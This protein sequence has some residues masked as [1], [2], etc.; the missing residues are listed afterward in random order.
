MAGPSERQPRQGW[1]SVGTARSALALLMAALTGCY[2][3][4]SVTRIPHDKVEQV[5]RVPDGT[6]LTLRTFDVEPGVLAVTAEEQAMC[7]DLE[8]GRRSYSIQTI[9]SKYGLGRGGGS[10]G[11]SGGGVHNAVWG[12]ICFITLPVCVAVIAVGGVIGLVYMSVWAL[13]PDKQVSEEPSRERPVPYREWRSEQVGCGQPARVV[14]EIPFRVVA[15]LN[16]T[17]CLEWRTVTAA[18]GTPSPLPALERTRASV[19]PCDRLVATGCVWIEP[20]GD[21]VEPPELPEQAQ[22]QVA[23][24]THGALIR[25]LAPMEADSLGLAGPPTGKAC[26]TSLGASPASIKDVVAVQACASTM[27]PAC[28]AKLDA[29]LA[30]PDAFCW[31]TALRCLPRAPEFTSCMIGNMM[32]YEDEPALPGP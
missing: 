23:H 12:A 9:D 8:Q 24:R 29:C 13:L 16:Q 11:G 5:E 15:R 2:Y 1:W 22:P 7:R 18:D 4:A 25:T 30:G 10:G 32:P 3:T 20:V 28:R 31:S 14:P 27:A 17:Q 19:V 26:R 6:Q 21:V